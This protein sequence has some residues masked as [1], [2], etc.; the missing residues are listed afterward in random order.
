MTQLALMVH[1][2]EFTSYMVD[3]FE[4]LRTIKLFAA[5]AHYQRLLVEK[6]S[7]MVGA[8]FNNRVAMAL[9]SAWSWLAT[10]LVTA[11]ILWYGSGRVLAGQI[12]AGELLVLFG[13]VTFYLTP[14]QRFPNIVL[15]IRTALI[16]VDRI[17]EICTLPTEAARTVAPTPLPVVRGRIV[18]D[19]VSFAYNRYKTVLKDVCLAIEPGETVAIVGETGSG[20]TSLAN[21]IAG[22]YLPTRGD[23]YIDGVST[24]NLNPEELRQAVSA[25][26]QNAR[27]LQQSVRENITMMGDVPFEAVRAAA[28]VAQADAFIGTLLNGYEAQVARGG[29]NFS[30]GQT[31]RIALARALLKNAPILILDEATSNLDGATEHAFLQALEAGRHG[32]TTVVIAHRL[33]TVRYADRILVMDSGTLVEAGTHDELLGCRGRYY[34]LFH[35]QLAD[36]HP[37]AEMGKRRS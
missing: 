25:V 37:M 23:V 7:A 24:R 11:W 22:F 13:M 15:T 17:E 36:N 20:K 26:F 1:G 16:G 2:E 32:R 3:S 5:E 28:Q 4:G 9:P 6:L 19:Q 30:S 12:S 35:G 27:L 31:Q 10:A 29:D 33:S 34:E 8:R 21:L 18:F 14:V